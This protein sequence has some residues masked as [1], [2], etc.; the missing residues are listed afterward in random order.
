MGNYS[1]PLPIPPLFLAQLIPR[2]YRRVVAAVALQPL[3]VRPERLAVAAGGTDGVGERE[4]AA[5]ALD[6]ARLTAHDGP[7]LGGLVADLEQPAVD[8]DVAAVN[9]EHHDVARRHPHHGIPGA[10]PQS[11]GAGGT[12]AGPAFR[13]EAGRSYS[14]GFHRARHPSDATPGRRAAA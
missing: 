5:D 11:M 10:A 7:A 3:R 4:D 12:H 6:E 9:V 13:L 14:A 8:G 2:Q 1:N